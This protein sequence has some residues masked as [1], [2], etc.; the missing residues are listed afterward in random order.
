MAK[1]TIC[2]WYDKDAEAAARFYAET[3]PDST[4]GAVHR[5]PGDYPVRQ[6]G[7]VLTVDFTVAGVACI[8]LNGG[9]DVQAQ[10]SLLVPDRDRRSGGDRPVLERH[11]RQWRRGERLRLVQGPVG[12]LLADHPARADGGDGRR[13]R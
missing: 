4:V 6:G 13:R 2:I 8:G 5:A 9:P 3:F 12:R 7:R 10:R 1:N 11:R